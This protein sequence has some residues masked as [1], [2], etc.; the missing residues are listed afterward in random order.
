MLRSPRHGV[1]D[2]CLPVAFGASSLFHT[3]GWGGTLPERRVPAYRPCVHLCA[4]CRQLHAGVARCVLLTAF[5]VALG[6]VAV[7]PFVKLD[8][9]LSHR[10]SRFSSRWSTVLDKRSSLCERSVD[11]CTGGVSD[12][13]R[14]STSLSSPARPRTSR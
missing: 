2:S 8:A 14:R 13:I 1:Y 6:W 5:Y 11:P 4:H 10:L 9:T 3:A 12:S 7:I